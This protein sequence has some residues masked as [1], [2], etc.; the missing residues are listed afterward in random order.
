MFAAGAGWLKR[1]TG[2]SNAIWISPQLEAP[3]GKTGIP[4]DHDDD[5][6]AWCARREH[7]LPPRA[8]SSNA[9]TLLRC[10]LH[11]ARVRGEDLRNRPLA[12]PVERLICP[13]LLLDCGYVRFGGWIGGE[14][15]VPLSQ[16]LCQPLP[17]LFSPG[18]ASSRCSAARQAGSHSAARQR[19]LRGCG[20]HTPNFPRR[21]RRGRGTLAY[22]ASDLQ[23]ARS[24]WNGQGLCRMRREKRWTVGCDR[25]AFRRVQIL[26]DTRD[27]NI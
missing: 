1:Q 10:A 2:D 9:S 7:S 23:I 6:I 21:I 13:P 26:P 18:R 16:V 11:S 4:L 22:L 25:S 5:R 12:Q 14:L 15:V 3:H 27:G 17:S 8:R 19:H 20:W 24:V